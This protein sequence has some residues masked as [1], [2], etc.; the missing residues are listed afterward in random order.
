MPVSSQTHP[1]RAFITDTTAL[2][3]FFAATGIMNERF[4]AGMGGVRREAQHPGA[5]W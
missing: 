1:R 3:L 4:I 5:L 2:I